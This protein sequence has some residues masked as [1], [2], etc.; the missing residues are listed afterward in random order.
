PLDPARYADFLQARMTAHKSQVWLVNTGWTGGPY[1]QGTRIK[2]S[3]TRA[4]LRAALGGALAGV[5]FAPDPVFGVLVP[6]SCPDMPSE[7][8]RPRTTWKN[9]A[10]YDS[11]ARHLAT[12]FQANFKPFAAQTAREVQSAGPRA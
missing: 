2:L 11:R 4:L 9:P 12:L 1:G 10:N 3:H 8:L 6:E 5:P 7:L